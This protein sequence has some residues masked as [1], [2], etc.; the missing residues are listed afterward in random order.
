MRVARAWRRTAR[1]QTIGCV[2]ILAAALLTACARR[3]LDLGRGG[4]SAE[5]DARLS[6]AFAQVRAQA[7]Q[8]RVSGLSYGPRPEPE[9]LPEPELAVSGESASLSRGFQAREVSRVRLTLYL[10]KSSYTRGY[11]KIGRDGAA[12]EVWRVVAYQLRGQAD[13]EF[14]FIYLLADPGGALRTLVLLGGTYAEGNA[15]RFA[16]EGA[17]LLPDPER[18]VKAFAPDAWKTAYPFAFVR[19][20][21]VPPRY[22]T[23]TVEA[24]EL[25][26]QVNRDVEE[27]ERLARRAEA[28]NAE[29]AKPD[30]NGT[31]QPSDSR[32]SAAPGT[33][34]GA[35]EQAAGRRADLEQ[36]V[37]QRAALAQAKAVHG[38]QV[39]AQA[40]SAFA[41]YLQT[42]AYSWRDADGRQE[43]FRKWEALDKQAALLEERVA[44]L[45]PYAPEPQRVEE[46]RA[47]ALAAVVKNN[48]ASR[49]PAPAKE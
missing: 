33:A 15:D 43:A 36:R 24:A 42:N 21:P 39:R 35:V 10:D 17:L 29:G 47:Q 9:G 46:A 19:G 1:R 41:A 2:A 44:Q 18:G 26:Q 37:R 6:L 34:P 7:P 13:R 25:V 40:D 27:L 48:N 31:A 16:I 4:L 23:L 22:Q 38:Y 8:D 32:P 49:R 20:E 45:L 30:G 3:D 28:L 5:D 14:E 11:A 12:E